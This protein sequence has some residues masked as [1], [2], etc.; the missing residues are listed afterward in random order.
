MSTN[1]KTIIRPQING[2][3]WPRIGLA[4]GSGASKAICQFGIL[5]RIQQHQIPISYVTGS[6]MGAI[7]GAAFALGL[8]LDH[9]LEKAVHYAEKTS[10]NS[11]SQINLLHE[12]LYKK[13][14]IDNLLREIFADFTFEECKIPLTV[15]AV[16]LESGKIVPLNKGLLVPAVRASTSIP[17]IF[18]PVLLNERYLV[19]GGLLEDCPI[20]TLQQQSQ[21][22]LTIGCY[23]KDQKHRQQISAY[24]YSKFYRKKPHGGLGG[25]LE[26]IKTDMHLLGATVLRSLDILRSEVWQYKLAE[27][28]PDLLISINIEQVDLFDF[29][30]VKEL[31]KT[32]EKAFDDHYPQL[33]LLIEEKKKELN[34]G[35]INGKLQTLPSTPTDKQ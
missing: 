30:K 24:I 17:G 11:L 13:D 5:K 4:L 2:I 7:I 34:K 25:K 19:D 31:I 6:S 28:K 29:K 32:G 18:E 8:D 3:T 9:V 22:D 10:I 35:G 23:I 1:K 15:T 16:D 33:Q 20:P 27:T 14:F 21:N 12:S 26:K